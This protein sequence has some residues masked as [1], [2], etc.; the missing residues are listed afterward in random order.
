M[1]TNMICVVFAY[2]FLLFSSLCVPLYYV[3][4]SFFVLFYCSK[5]FVSSVYVLLGKQGAH[6]AFQWLMCCECSS[7]A[8]KTCMV[9]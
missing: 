1:H 4:E 8:V 2:T 7:A 5:R 6:A 9:G 3:G